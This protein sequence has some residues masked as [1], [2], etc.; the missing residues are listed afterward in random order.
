VNSVVTATRLV[1]TH[2]HSSALGRWE[3]V[4]AAPHP[5]LRPFVRE[6]VGGSEWTREPLVRRELPTEIAPVIFSFGAP[7]RVFD[8]ADPARFVDRGSFATGPFDRFVLVGS[9][10]SYSCVQV[11]FTI[12]GARLFLGVPLRDLANHVVPLDEVLGVAGR[13]L[14]EDLGNIDDWAARFDRLDREIMTRLGAAT[15]PPS[16]AWAVQQ[17]IRRHGQIAI[18]TLAET[19]GWSHRHLVKQ[20]TDQI[21]LTPKVLARVLRFGRAADRLADVSGGH[22]ADIAADCGYYDQAHFTR[23]FR[24][25]AGVTPTELLAS[26]L[27]NRGGF[28]A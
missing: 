12:L 21:G 5:S 8:A 23:D 17:L 28:V 20:F 10:G 15:L 9:T 25:F 27:P 3:S 18:G 13:R 2:Q 1:E 26:R 22:L 24:A 6:Y 19:T 14:V 16:L 11:N 7:F 4:V